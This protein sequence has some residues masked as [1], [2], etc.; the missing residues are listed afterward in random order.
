MRRLVF[1]VRMTFGKWKEANPNL[2]GIDDAP[3]L[4]A[5]SFDKYRTFF[6]K[7]HLYH[8]GQEHPNF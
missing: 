8:A 1:G 6:N 3:D 4:K 5:K 2:G 7:S